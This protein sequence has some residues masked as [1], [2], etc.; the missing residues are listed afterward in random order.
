VEETFDPITAKPSRIN[1]MRARAKKKSG[2][3]EQKKEKKGT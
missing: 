1:H 3:V 2:Q